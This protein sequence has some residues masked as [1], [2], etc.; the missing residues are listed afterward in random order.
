LADRL[1]TLGIGL[2]TFGVV[3]SIGAYFLLSSIPL[4][5]LGIGITILGITTL[6]T[7]SQPIP[8]ETI[9]D[10]IK[11]SCDNI[12]SILEATGAFI[13]AIYIPSSNEKVY[14][15]IPLVANPHI[16]PPKEV[17]QYLDKVVVKHGRSVGIVITPPG[18]E[19]KKLNVS[20]EGS[21]DLESLVEQ[22][23]VD[24]SG[25]AEGIKLLEEG[26]S[27]ILEVRRP[28]VNV[29]YPR[30]NLVM[31]S[32]PSC[33]AAQAIAL[34]LSTPIQIGEEKQEKDRIVTRFQVLEW[35]EIPS[36]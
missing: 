11:S 18:F 1:I 8:K 14:A 28:R 33:M 16:P 15:Y 12:E 29:D 25:I 27:I 23:L 24:L 17:S 10:L 35:T 19:L 6:L 32:L 22:I 7:P 5:A 36:I 2:T 30:F 31:G 26:N 20:Q 21:R 9:A 34:A 4:T 13:K 3:F